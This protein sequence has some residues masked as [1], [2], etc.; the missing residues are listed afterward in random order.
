MVDVDAALREATRAP[1]A[2]AEVTATASDGVVVA[3]WEAPMDPGGAPVSGYDVQLRAASGQWQAYGNIWPSTLRQRVL[4]DLTNGWPTRCGSRRTTCSEPAT[5][6][7]RMSSRRSRYPARYRFARCNTRP[8]PASDSA[9]PAL[10]SVD[11][12]A[13]PTQPSQS[14]SHTVAGRAGLF[15]SNHCATAGRVRYTVEVRGLNALGAG[16]AA[17]RA[18]ATPTKPGKV[19]ALKAVRKGKRLTVRWREPKRTGLM[20]RYRLRV[21]GVTRWQRTK[22]TAVTVKRVGVGPCGSRCNR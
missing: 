13:V 2:P 14:L 4:G 3:S 21:A 7:N 8:R 19:R 17:R 22:K 5:G 1:G 11:R 10:G 12:D 18:I 20:P 15:A 6:A 16:P 9:E